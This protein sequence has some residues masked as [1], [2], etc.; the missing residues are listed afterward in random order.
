MC[1]QGCCKHSPDIAAAHP[2]GR[3]AGRE[4]WGDLVWDSAVL[5]LHK[6]QLMMSVIVLYRHVADVMFTL[7]LVVQIA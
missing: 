6:C 2:T 3:A 5:Y 7:G 4:G 1:L